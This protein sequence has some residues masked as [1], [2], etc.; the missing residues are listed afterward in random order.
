MTEQ[1]TIPSGYWQDASG[2]LVPE[3]KVK[4]IDKLRHQV[5]TE[6]CNAARHERAGLVRFKRRAFDDVAALVATSLEQYGIKTGGEKGNVTLTS[7]D[8]KFKVVRHMQ[9]HIV[10]GE[11]LMAAKVLIDQCVKTWAAGANDNIMALVNHA[12]QTDKEGRINT[13]RVLSL[14]RL[15]IA[16][17]Q[18][19]A[20]MEAIADSM[21]TASTTAYIRFYERDHAEASWRA[22]ALDMAAL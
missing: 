1:N 18:W 14:R 15:N 4:D 22:I 3:S 21:T 10:F 11:Q 2:N 13:G 16:D 19:Q 8:G 7:Y 5:V 12:F 20:A 6:L 17:K 9:D